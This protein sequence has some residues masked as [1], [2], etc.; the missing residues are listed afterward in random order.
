[1][2]EQHPPQNQFPTERWARWNFDINELAKQVNHLHG[3]RRIWM[4]YRE[5]RNL[6]DVTC[7]RR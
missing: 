4:E 1:M 2:S 7:P 6:T 3:Q 5:A